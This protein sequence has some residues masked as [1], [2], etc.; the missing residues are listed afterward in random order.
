MRAHERIVF[1]G[2]RHVVFAAEPHERIVH[3]TEE[4]DRWSRLLQ[5]LARPVRLGSLAADADLPRDLDAALLERLVRAGHL[6]AADDPGPLLV[7]RAGLCTKSPAFHLAPVPSRCGRLIVGCTGSVVAGLMA[8]TYLSLRHCRFQDQLDVILTEAAQR[9]LTRDLLKAYGLRCWSDGFERQEGIRVPHVVLAQAADLICVLPATADAL[10]R[11]A[12][13]ACSD[14]LSLCI[15]AS[16]APVIL[17]P[18]M[19]GAMWNNPGIQRNVESLRADGRYIIEP[20]FIFGAA[21]FEA[22]AE[23]MYGGHGTLWSGPAGLIY[24]LEALLALHHGAV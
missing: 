2:A 14:L 6:L 16:T 21:D 9:F 18:A 5:H 1:T 17:V 23:P 7:H 10:D 12:R 11:I 13:S 24:A 4:P 15:A 8:A 3:A 22:D 19:N 20:T